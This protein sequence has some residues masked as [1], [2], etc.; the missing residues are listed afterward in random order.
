MFLEFKKFRIVLDWEATPIL[1]LNSSNPNGIR[2]RLEDIGYVYNEGPPHD[3][4][5]HWRDVVYLEEFRRD[6][7][8][9]LTEVYVVVDEVCPSHIGED[10]SCRSGF[11]L[12]PRLYKDKVVIDLGLARDSETP[13]YFHD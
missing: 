6:I 3:H 5:E 10:C 1:V 9:N 7:L 11:M 12:T 13:Y 8:E 2:I 4:N